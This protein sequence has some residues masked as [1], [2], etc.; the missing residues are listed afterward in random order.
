MNIRR[1]ADLGVLIA[2]L[3]ADVWIADLLTDVWIAD[4]LTMCGLPIYG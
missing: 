4:L 3:L 1:I 2:D